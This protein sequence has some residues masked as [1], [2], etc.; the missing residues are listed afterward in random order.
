M[1]YSY[2][3][4]FHFF[5]QLDTRVHYTCFNFEMYF[6]F[7]EFMIC[8]DLGLT[9]LHSILYDENYKKEIRLIIQ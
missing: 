6:L 3:E 1:N 7:V 5:L 2:N 8:F 9:Q 4:I